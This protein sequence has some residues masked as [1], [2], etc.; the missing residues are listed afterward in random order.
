MDGLLGDEV[1]EDDSAGI[2]RR[3]AAGGVDE[4]VELGRLGAED[5][6]GLLRRVYG[7]FDLSGLFRRGIFDCL[8]NGAR[9]K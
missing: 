3:I 7:I 4:G 2:G 1:G 5:P 9:T 6:S 8:R